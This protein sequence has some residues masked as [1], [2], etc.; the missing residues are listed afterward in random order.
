MALDDGDGRSPMHLAHAPQ[1]LAVLFNFFYEIGDL[2]S[3]ADLYEPDAAFFPGGGR[4]ERGRASILAALR[5]LRDDG[6]LIELEPQRVHQ[7]GGVAV[8]S[9]RAIVGTTLSDS[10]PRV[11]RTVEV[12][13]RSVDGSWRYVIGDPRFVSDLRAE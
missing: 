6:V 3:L 11:L 7:A 2:E 1:D 5:G 8:L 13:R 4:E 10:A 9:N 12:A